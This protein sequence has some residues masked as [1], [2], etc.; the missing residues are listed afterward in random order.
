MSSKFISS[1]VTIDDTD[2]RKSLLSNHILSSIP[3]IYH[4]HH[5]QRVLKCISQALTLYAPLKLQDMIANDMCDIQQ[6]P[7][8]FVFDMLADYTGKLEHGGKW[9]LLSPN[10]TFIK[11]LGVIISCKLAIIKGSGDCARLSKQPKRL[12]LFGPGLL[13]EVF[14]VHSLL[15]ICLYL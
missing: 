4:A 9:Q 6:F 7:P 5:S 15:H 2:E 8:P 10:E 1:P 13:G 14:A 11:K 3:P 12:A